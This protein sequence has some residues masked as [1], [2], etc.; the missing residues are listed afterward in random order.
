MV[1][2]PEAADTAYPVSAAVGT[3]AADTA[4]PVAVVAVVVDTAFPAAAVVGTVAAVV[5]AV[6]VHNYFVD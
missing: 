3:V 1:P 6:A 2:A 5:G 4:Y